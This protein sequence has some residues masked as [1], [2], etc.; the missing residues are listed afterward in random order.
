MAG[1]AEVEAGDGRPGRK[2]P[3]PHL[4]GQ[5]FALEDV[6]SGEARA[7][8]DIG[9]A[10]HLPVLHHLGHVGGETGDGRQGPVAGSSRRVLQSPQSNLPGTYCAKTLIVCLPAGATI[11]S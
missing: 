10:Q 7:A 9:W 3:V 6:S 1:A 8:L 2:A 5:A 4:R 11:G